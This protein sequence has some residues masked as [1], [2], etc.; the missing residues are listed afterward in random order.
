MNRFFLPVINRTEKMSFLEPPTLVT[1]KYFVEN[2]MD[3]VTVPNHDNFRFSKSMYI[4]NPKIEDYGNYYLL[5]DFSIINTYVKFTYGEH[6]DII[7]WDQK[8]DVKI[9]MNKNKTTNDYYNKRFTPIYNCFVV[10][11][12]LKYYKGCPYYPVSCERMVSGSENLIYST[13]LKRLIDEEAW[14]NEKSKYYHLVD[15]ELTPEKIQEIREEKL[16]EE[17]KITKIQLT[18]QKIHDEVEKEDLDNIYAL[19]NDIKD[20]KIKNM[21][22]SMK[23]ILLSYIANVSENVQFHLQ[24]EIKEI[25]KVLN[26]IKD[27]LELYVH[28]I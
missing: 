20:G 19:Y 1:L 16:R 21:P 5:S 23:K 4:L 8:V 3:Y 12:D 11:L 9:R 25:Y 28:N 7:V 14:D 2:T 6:T 15:P 10:S 13:E 17:L 24:K 18:Q 27:D 26:N 22:N